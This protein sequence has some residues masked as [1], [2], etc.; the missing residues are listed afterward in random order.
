MRLIMKILVMLVALL[1]VAFGGWYLASQAHHAIDPY[2]G[3]P[4]QP[5]DLYAA[6]S[7][8]E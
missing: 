1:G 5:G 8:R 2:D 6:R 4:V 3:Q 7:H